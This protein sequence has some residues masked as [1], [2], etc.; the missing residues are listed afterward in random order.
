VP[1]KVQLFG[2]VN[3]IIEKN[4]EQEFIQLLT[5]HLELLNVLEI[6]KIMKNT[7]SSV[8]GDAG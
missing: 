2:N 4:V 3:G 6:I 7:I 8:K 5:T 1:D